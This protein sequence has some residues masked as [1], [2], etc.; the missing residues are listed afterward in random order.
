[1]DFYPILPQLTHVDV[2]ELMTDWVG[3]VGGWLLQHVEGWFGLTFDTFVWVR[4][5]L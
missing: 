5:E 3:E 1:M 2:D 4:D